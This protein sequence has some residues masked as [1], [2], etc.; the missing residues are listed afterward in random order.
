MPSFCLAMKLQSG[1]IQSKIISRQSVT[2]LLKFGYT[3]RMINIVHNVKC[4]KNGRKMMEKSDVTNV[5]ANRGEKAGT[6]NRIVYYDFLRIIAICAV[7]VLHVSAQN[8]T[9]AGVDTLQW[10]AFNLYDSIVRW[11]VP[12]FVMISGALFLE[13]EHSIEKL[14]K[15]NVARIVMSFVFW[16]LLYAIKNMLYTHC[17]WKAALKQFLAGQGHMWFLFMIVGLYMIVPLVK[18]IVKFVELTKYFLLLSLAFTFVV[19]QAINLVSLRYPSISS[20]VN[21]IWSKVYFHFTLGFVCYFVCGYFLSKADLS[22]KTRGTIYFLAICGFISTIVG[23][24]W[25]SIS[26]QKPNVMLYDYFSITVMLEALGIFVFVKDRFDG[27]EIGQKAERVLVLLSKYSFGVYLVHILV[28]D[29]LARI[30]GLNTLSFNPLLS[31]PV[32][33][34]IVIVVSFAISAALNHIPLLK[35]TV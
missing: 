21:S 33:S 15:R 14:Y 27:R 1:E 28:L 32:I 17:G 29:E 3:F 31:V 13:G 20:F 22:K 23:T 34:A 26:Q 7:I 25:I 24:A 5:T 4:K 2:N 12:V 19:P 6:E 16:S 9:H 11:G 10:Q 35:K 18:P 30:F 8:F